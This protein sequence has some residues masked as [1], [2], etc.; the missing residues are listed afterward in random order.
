MYQHIGHSNGGA[1]AT[2]PLICLDGESGSSGSG[3]IRLKCIVLGAAGAGKTSI[4][5]RY[6]RGTFE[7][8]A[9]STIGAD[10]YPRRVANPVRLLSDDG[11]DGGQ[12][13]TNGGTVSGSSLDTNIDGSF[14]SLRS[15]R[16]DSGG[17]L[18]VSLPSSA[19]QR[20]APPQG[21]HGNSSPRSMSRGRRRREK[22]PPEWIPSIVREPHVNL[23]MW[24]TAGRERMG[25]SSASDKS[26]AGLSSCL[27]DAFFRHA[28]VAMLC[29]D[30]TSSRSFTQLIRWHSELTER[31]SRFSGGEDK[32]DFGIA[33]RGGTRPRGVRFP[34]LVVANKVDRLKTTG[35]V[36]ARSIRPRVVP[37]R[38]VMG[39]GGQF[40]GKDHRYEYS[41]SGSPSSS[42]LPSMKKNRKGRPV[43]QRQHN[44]LSYALTDTT[45][46]TEKDYLT[47]VIKSEDVSFPDRDMVILWCRRN[48]LG[49]VE[50]S[51]LDGTGIEAAIDA[52]IMLGLESLNERRKIL[53]KREENA[54]K[55]HMTRRESLDLHKRYAPKEQTGCCWR[56][57]PCFK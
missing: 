55:C 56:L 49:H 7:Y 2:P 11:D 50:V 9:R 18:S 10:F 41:V 26:S 46:T 38:D 20:G 42:D 32:D 53:A 21:G 48:G 14:R 43:G 23:Q 6:F 29:Y 4:L 24:D 22:K 39:L 52:V 5:R 40:R 13:S 54:W 31:M 45:W 12:A 19:S 28:N 44:R 1:A 47:S 27:G 25:G 34:I 36:A 37:Q 35:S 33:G 15:S 30:A 17:E 51:A 57:L 8:G 16:S 3:R